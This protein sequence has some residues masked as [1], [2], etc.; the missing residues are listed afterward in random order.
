MVINGHK[1]LLIRCDTCGRV[2]EYDL[3]L[4]NISREILNRFKCTCGQ[5]NVSLKT[6]NYKDY[7]LGINCFACGQRHFYRLSLRQLFCEEN[8]YTCLGD[9]KT[10][11]IGSSEV[12][13]EL[14]NIKKLE[15][16]DVMGGREYKNQFNNYKIFSAC[17]NEI[18]KLQEE[19]KVFCECG[20][21][22]MTLEFF[23]DRIELKCGNCNSVQIIF[24]ETEE[25]LDILKR[26][27][28]IH[29]EEH[30]I[31]CLDSLY[32][33]NKDIKG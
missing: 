6:V 4:F 15:L 29:M 27:K 7:Y 25:D 18:N 28:K 14:L 33:K 17:L 3:N 23:S 8:M 11:F 32:E 22:D 10:C 24:A 31:A 21:K 26:K 2:R 1:T 5:T 13:N 19:G 30:N 16:D 9:M 20:N 12:A